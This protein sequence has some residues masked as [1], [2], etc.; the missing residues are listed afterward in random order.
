MK[1]IQETLLEIGGYIKEQK[2]TIKFTE[3]IE[4]FMNEKYPK[5]QK[6]DLEYIELMLGE[7][8]KEYE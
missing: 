4:K 3:I 5:L 2:R 1:S 7:H 8:N 6:V